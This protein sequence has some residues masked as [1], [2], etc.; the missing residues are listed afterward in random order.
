MG[1]EWY[2][3]TGG[4][5]SRRGGGEERDSASTPSGCMCAVFQ[6][7]DFHQFQFALHQQ[8][9]FKPNSFLPEETSIPK[10]IFP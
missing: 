8:T 9:S 5:S 2:W 10:G 7:F 4:K 6:L 1:R 3:G